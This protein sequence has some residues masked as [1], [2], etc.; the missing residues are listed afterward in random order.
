[1]KH[2]R[3]GT[4]VLYGQKNIPCPN[5]IITL[6]LSFNS[7]ELDEYNTLYY[8]SFPFLACGNVR[9]L[10]DGVFIVY[11]GRNKQTSLE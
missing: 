2:S 4:F 11:T 6:I 8:V 1:M 10:R 5:F 9:F 3:H 7:L